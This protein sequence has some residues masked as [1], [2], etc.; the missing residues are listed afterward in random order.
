MND[1][2]QGLIELLHGRF[3]AHPERHP[4]IDWPEVATRLLGDPVKLTILER[5]EQ[6][7]G[8]PDVIAYDDSIDGFIFCDCSAESPTGRRSLCYDDAA[9]QARKKNKPAGSAVDQA[10]AMGIELLSEADYRYLQSLG[11]FDLKTSS[12]IITPDSVRQRGGALFGDRR[13]DQVFIYHNGADSYYAA[14]GFRG[15]LTV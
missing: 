13:Y 11:E 10:A 14:R 4:G 8:E 3:K 1:L 15:R 7:G 2:H 12:W 5:M 6:S 9:L